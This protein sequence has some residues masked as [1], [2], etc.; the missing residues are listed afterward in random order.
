M[1]RVIAVT[2]ARESPN[3]VATMQREIAALR[4]QIDTMRKELHSDIALPVDRHT[5]AARRGKKP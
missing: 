5:V 1:A 3:E 4:K 2:Y